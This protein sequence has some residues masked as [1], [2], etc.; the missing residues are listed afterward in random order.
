MERNKICKMLMRLG[1][2][3]PGLLDSSEGDAK[4]A[5]AQYQCLRT[6]SAVGP[7]FNCASPRECTP[8]RG[9]CKLA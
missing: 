3:Y 8:H 2:R 1:P 4:S 9:C 6:L 7:D 5:T